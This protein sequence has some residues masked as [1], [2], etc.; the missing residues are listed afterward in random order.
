M[1]ASIHVGVR[2]VQKMFGGN[3]LITINEYV[4]AVERIF[5]RAEIWIQPRL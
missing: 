2:A 3:Y 1:Y 5:E 4:I